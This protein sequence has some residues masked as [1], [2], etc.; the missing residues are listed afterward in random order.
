MIKKEATSKIEI[1]GMHCASCVAA[2]EKSIAKVPGVQKVAVNLATESASVEFADGGDLFDD[3]RK[4][5]ENAGYQVTGRSDD[6]T[7]SDTEDELEK[8]ERKIRT[9]RRKM[10]IGWAATIPIMLWMLPEMISGFVVGGMTVF[11][12]GMVVLSSVVLFGPGRDTFRS[13]LKSAVHLTPNMD[14]LI[15]IG[16]LA[17]LATGVVAVLHEF[18]IGPAFA[19]FGG[20]AG[21]IMAFHLTGRFIETKAKGRASQAIK[22]LLTLE[23]KNATVERNGKEVEVPVASLQIGDVMVV[24]PG[25][26]I[27]TDGI[28][29]AGESTV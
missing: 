28:V 1:E 26:K 10:W 27:P 19:N 5:V 4:A 8:D 15:A 22:R 29:V 24:R 16:T 2:V 6:E 12:I 14:V 7:V 21:M 11:N 13:G 23:A 17:A 20:V 18:G 25:E 9:A 3:I